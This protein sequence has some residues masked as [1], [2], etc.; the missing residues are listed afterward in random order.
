MLRVS[1]LV[2]IIGALCSYLPLFMGNSTLSTVFF[3]TGVTISL[4]IWYILAINRDAHYK[5]LQKK[6]ILD[7]EE[8]KHA[9]LFLRRRAIPYV[10]AYSF[11][12]TALQLSSMGAMKILVENAYTLSEVTDT[13]KLIEVLGKEYAIYSA[14]FLVSLI[15]TAFLFYKLI[16][17]I[18]NDEVKMQLMVSRKRRIPA[19]IPGTISVWLVVLFTIISYGVFSWYFRYKLLMVQVLY[20][21]FREKLDE[22]EDDAKKKKEDLGKQQL[23]NA[24]NTEKLKER[25]ISLLENTPEGNRRKEIIAALFRDLGGLSTKDASIV[26]KDLLEKALLS[27]TEYKKLFKLL[28]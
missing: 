3:A 22:L 4:F 8:L 14:V 12:F 26:L 18:Y 11:S 17:I 24:E 19:L 25:Y 15:S 13:A 10:I 28:F 20:G 21:R 7:S 6:G 27:E 9:R 1:S 5:E 16:D 23:L 2:F